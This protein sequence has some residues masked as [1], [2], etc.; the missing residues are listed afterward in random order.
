MHTEFLWG[1]LL[2]NGHLLDWKELWGGWDWLGSGLY[3]VVDFSIR[4]EFAGC[5]YYQ[6]VK[7]CV[8]CHCSLLL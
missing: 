3:Q 4:V 7:F 8:Q 5:A 6:R 1:T 2:A